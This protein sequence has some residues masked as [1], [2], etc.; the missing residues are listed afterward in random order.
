MTDTPPLPDSAGGLQE[1]LVPLPE[2]PLSPPPGLL[3]SHPPSVRLSSSPASSPRIV[4]SP[5]TRTQSIHPETGSLLPPGPQGE[6]ETDFLSL[7]SDDDSGW[8]DDDGTRDLSDVERGGNRVSAATFESTR[9]E[10]WE[11][12]GRKRQSQ[13]LTALP[14]FSPPAHDSAMEDVPSSTSAARRPPSQARQLSLK[15]YSR[16]NVVHNRGSPRSSI[17]ST[18]SSDVVPRPLNV[19][20]TVSQNVEDAG[21]R[22]SDETHRRYQGSTSETESIRMNAFL[23]AH[24]ATLHAIDSQPNSP[25]PAHFSF[26]HSTPRSFSAHRHIKLVPP[27]R[28]DGVDHEHDPDR[29]P[30]LPAHFIKTPYP[31]SPRKEFPPPKTRPR[32][33]LYVGPGGDVEKGGHGQGGMQ[34]GYERA[35][36]AQG[37]L[38]RGSPHSRSPAKHERW[39]SSRSTGSACESTIWLSLAR[40]R[41]RAEP[42]LVPLAIPSSLATSHAQ[43]H[44]SPPYKPRLRLDPPADYDDAHFAR[45]LRAAHARLVGSRVL[46][47]FSARKTYSVRL[48]RVSAWSGSSISP[49]SPK[50]G[51]FS[52]EGGA[53]SLLLAYDGLHASAEETLPFTEDALFALYRSPKSGSARYTWVHWARRLAAGNRPPRSPPSSRSRSLS[54][55]HDT[56]ADVDGDIELP[57]IVLT[58][59]F[60][61]RFAPGRVLSVGAVM[62]GLAVGAAVVYVFVGGEMSKGRLEEER[63]ARAVPGMLVGLFALGVEAVLFFAWV[64][65]SWMWV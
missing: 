7:S 52:S 16:I 51:I 25:L 39:N 56:D 30:H 13:Y 41:S 40:N 55:Q 29:P 24:Y 33:E 12:R 47:W 3:F 54:L 28:T 42:R 14:A 22:P 62:L 38:P 35:P 53:P 49:Y 4:G 60:V 43:V 10:E 11:E 32:T 58:V 31:F 64:V 5:P 15:R 20:R 9:S 6:G 17:L 8:E 44:G 18:G 19:S 36:S 1:P 61:R 27:L 45:D 34:D 46:R 21:P 48:A 50:S 23:N 59:Q 63:A 37:L 57:R 26:S 2:T 65:G